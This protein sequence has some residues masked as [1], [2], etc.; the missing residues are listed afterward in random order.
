M[1]CWAFSKGD[2]YLYFGSFTARYLS[3]IYRFSCVAYVIPQTP[4][5]L[6]NS[7]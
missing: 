5:D 1:L 2:V 7:S 3:I 4:Y 6:A